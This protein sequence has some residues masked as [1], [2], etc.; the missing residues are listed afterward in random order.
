MFRN[1]EFL[2]LTKLPSS[3]FLQQCRAAF[4][5]REALFFVTDMH[6]GGDLFFHLSVRGKEG[7]HGFSEKE[8]RVLLAEVVVGLEFLHANLVIHR[9]IKA[10]NSK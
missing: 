2:F 5:S 9:D 7:K 8:A 3:P 10:E 4:E 6:D 1:P